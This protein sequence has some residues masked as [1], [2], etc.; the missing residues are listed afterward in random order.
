MTTCPHSQYG[1]CPS[2]FASLQERLAEAQLAF[3]LQ[4]QRTKE[5]DAALAEAAQL[6]AAS[7]FCEKHQPNGGTRNCLVCGCIKLS[8][9]LHQIDYALGSP[10][11]MEVSDY[12]LH[13]N[14]DAVVERVKSAL[15]ASRER[16]AELERVKIERLELAE[17]CFIA[18]CESAGDTVSRDYAYSRWKTSDIKT[19]L[20]INEL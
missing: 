15:T 2:C 9:A 19:D 18:G 4:I 1:A 11:E 14:E 17:K 12:S 5:R 7:G 6:K 8:N 13:A 20:E 3:D 16:V 10:N